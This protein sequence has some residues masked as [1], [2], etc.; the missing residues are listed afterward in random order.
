MVM[1]TM[2]KKMVMA[3]MEKKMVDNP[4]VLSEY[5]EQHF[6]HLLFSYSLSY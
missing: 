2:E 5:K 4:N 3:T 1:A 6:S